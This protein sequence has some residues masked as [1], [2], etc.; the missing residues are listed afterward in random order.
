MTIDE[1]DITTTS[2]SWSTSDSACTVSVRIESPDV[3]VRFRNPTGTTSSNSLV[4][5]LSDTLTSWGCATAIANGFYHFDSFSAPTFYHVT[6]KFYDVIDED[7]VS[8]RG[9]I[10]KRPAIIVSLEQQYVCVTRYE[11]KEIGDSYSTGHRVAFLVTAPRLATTR[12]QLPSNIRASFTRLR[13]DFW[14][15]DMIYNEPNTASDLVISNTGQTNFEVVVIFRCTSSSCSGTI[16]RPHHDV[17]LKSGQEYLIGS[18]FAT[19]YVLASSCSHCLVEYDLFALSSVSFQH[20]NSGESSTLY[21]GSGTISVDDCA[22]KT[23]EFSGEE[24]DLIFTSTCFFDSNDNVY[25]AEMSKS[26]VETSALSLQNGDNKGYVVLD[27]PCDYCYLSGSI[28]SGEYSVLFLNNIYEYR[29]FSL[30]S[31]GPSFVN[32]LSF[33]PFS[34]SSI[35]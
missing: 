12:L 10:V 18:T 5:V 29:S 30:E 6:G 1:R 32:H 3:F 8:E 31:F 17:I 33:I 13:G 7:K 9:L 26:I 21:Q 11:F 24:G 25:V 35:S 23:L 22:F 34:S 15:S 14:Y 16:P 4:F 19:S 27:D 20:T 2:R 28:Y